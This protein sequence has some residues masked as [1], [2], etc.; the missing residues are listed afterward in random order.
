MY[1]QNF[2]LQNIALF[3]SH[4]RSNPKLIFISIYCCHLLSMWIIRI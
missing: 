3:C 1:Y 2:K 4:S